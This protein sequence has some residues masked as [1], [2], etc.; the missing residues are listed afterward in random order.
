MRAMQRGMSG[1]DVI[2]W[3]SFLAGQKLFRGTTSGLFDDETLQSTV[4][5]QRLHEMLPASG[6]VDNRTLGMA[7]V[8]GLRLFEEPDK[9]GGE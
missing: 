5:F 1:D 3:Q 9:K 6:V 7:M 2:Q 8:V 4:D